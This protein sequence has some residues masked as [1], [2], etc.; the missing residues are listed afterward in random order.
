MIIMLCRVIWEAWLQ[1]EYIGGN[2]CVFTI[3]IKVVFNEIGC[4]QMRLLN[5][6]LI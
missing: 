2:A 4:V 1:R 3:K 6:N 5:C